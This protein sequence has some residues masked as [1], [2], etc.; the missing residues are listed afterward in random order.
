MFHSHPLLS[1][2]D[3]SLVHISY[4]FVLCL[5]THAPSPI[6]YV[7]CPF[8]NSMHSLA[9]ITGTQIFKDATLFFLRS[10]PHLATVIPAMDHIDKILTTNS[11]DNKFESSIRAA[12]GLAKKT[13]NCYYNKTDHSE[14]YRIAMGVCFTHQ[15]F[16]NSNKSVISPPPTPQTPIFQE[17]QLGTRLDQRR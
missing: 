2:G 7:D 13:L 17:G 16:Y 10:T 11:L 3:S 9:I 5:S 4:V 14:V 6:F 15:L 8:L 12:L 1:M